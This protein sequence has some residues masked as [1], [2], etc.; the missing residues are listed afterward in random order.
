MIR[1]FYSSFEP[2][3]FLDYTILEFARL[4]VLAD[5]YDCPR[6]KHQAHLRGQLQMARCPGTR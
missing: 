4:Y 3:R 1:F 5:K 6:V 2:V